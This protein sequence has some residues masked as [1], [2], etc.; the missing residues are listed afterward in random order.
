[1]RLKRWRFPEVEWIDRPDVIVTLEAHRRL[2]P[3][4]QPVGIDDRMAGRLDDLGILES[5][6]LV[7][8]G[9]VAGGATD[10]TGA[11][12]LARDARDPQEVVELAQTLLAR[13]FEKFLRRCHRRLS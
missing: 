11:L 3:R 13:L 5:D 8:L 1:M 2:C 6:A 9:Q 4:L 7:L 10:V 12:R